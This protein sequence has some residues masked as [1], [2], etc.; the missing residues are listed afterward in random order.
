MPTT[1]KRSRKKRATPPDY[2]GIE[3]HTERHGLFF[4]RYRRIRFERTGRRAAVREFTFQLDLDVDG[5]PIT[6]PRHL[7]RQRGRSLSLTECDQ[8]WRAIQ[9]LRPE[10]LSESYLCLDDLDTELLDSSRWAGDKTPIAVACGEEGPACL[11]LRTGRPKDATITRI[12]IDRFSA[13]SPLCADA[14]K[15]AKAPLSA[16]V[17]L[18]DPGLRDTQAFTYRQSRPLADLIAEFHSLKARDFLNLTEFE[19]HCLEALGSLGDPQVVPFLSGELFAPD[20]RVRLQALNAL[21]AIDDGSAARD[22]ELLCYDDE[23]EVRERARE[24]LER[25]GHRV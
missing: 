21:A 4:Y 10:R 9:G 23:P 12:V 16:I 8:L 1:G 5:R 6:R 7:V 15:S 24:V 18:V 19:P 14:L 2:W 20:P 17:A 3:F 25:L 11:T 13:P 22:V